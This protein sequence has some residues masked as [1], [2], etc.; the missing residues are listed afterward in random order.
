V[1]ATADD[2]PAIIELPLN[3]TGQYHAVTQRDVREWESLY[4]AVDVGQQLRNMRG[5]LDANPKKRKTKGGILRFVNNW[6]AREQ[7]K[8]GGGTGGTQNRPTETFAEQQSRRIREAI[9][10]PN[11]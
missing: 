3:T 9:Y 7:D 10:D 5:W 4:P 11:F 6:L 2:L 8:G 1:E